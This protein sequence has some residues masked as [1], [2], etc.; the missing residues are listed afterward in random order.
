M[1]VAGTYYEDAGEFGDGGM[2]RSLDAGTTWRP[3]PNFAN[4]WTAVTCSADGTRMKATTSEGCNSC[5]GG[6]G[7]IYTSDD[8]GGTWTPD[9][10]GAESWH[11]VTS[12]ADGYRVVAAG[13]SDLVT[14][15]YSGPW[16]PVKAPDLHWQGAAV[17]SDGTRWVGVGTVSPYQKDGG[18]FYVS[19]DSGTTWPPGG[20]FVLPWNWTSLAASADGTRLVA[21]SAGGYSLGSHSVYLS[22]D[23]GANWTRTSTPAG[24]WYRVACSADGQRIALFANERNLN[25]RSICFLQSPAPVP[26]APPSPRLDVSLSGKD[27]ALSWLVPSTRFVL[28]QAAT[29]GSGT[30]SDL[31]ATPTL[32]LTNLHHRV[33][34]GGSPGNRYFRLK[35]Q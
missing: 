14:L 3:I 27:L 23:S 6:D 8:S 33:T 16:S 13:Y 29:L 7:L 22:T 21:I 20:H 5:A 26:P 30:W 34:L 19:H 4:N 10:E 18:R 9:T 28:Q 11:A 31:P 15:P 35:E 1:A 2:Y 32:D 25:G 24:P 17:S 12:S